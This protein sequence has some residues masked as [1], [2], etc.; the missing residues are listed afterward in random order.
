MGT[1]N[2]VQ[3]VPALRGVLTGAVPLNGVYY[4]KAPQAGTLVAAYVADTATLAASDT[5]YMTFTV[6]N[7][8]NSS[9]VMA[10]ATTKAASLDG[11]AAN[12]PEAVT[13]SAT[14]AN[15]KFSAGD[16]I[17]VEAAAAAS[18]TMTQGSVDLHV[19]YGQG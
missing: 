15:L 12:V 7:L 1:I 14:A 4:F 3:V 10:S 19:V 5:D 17:K 9:A 13:L 18:G 2:K 11:L 16:V 8:T 6:T